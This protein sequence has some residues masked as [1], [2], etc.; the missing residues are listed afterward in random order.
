MADTHQAET[1]NPGRSG[2]TP[3]SAPGVPRLLLILT[4]GPRSPPSARR[5]VPSRP[6]SPTREAAEEERVRVPQVAVLQQ[7]QGAGTPLS[8]GRRHHQEPPQTEHGQRHL[9]PRRQASPGSGRERVANQNGE[10]RARRPISDRQLLAGGQSEG[11]R[12]DPSAATV[13]AWRRSRCRAW[14]KAGAQ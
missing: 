14:E 3:P 8:A 4:R 1:W 6:P 10:P 5:G 7:H 11:R 2:E 13:A 9:A 12:Q